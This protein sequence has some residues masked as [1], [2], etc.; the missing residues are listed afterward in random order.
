MFYSSG[1][2]NKILLFWW[3]PHYRIKIN[4]KSN[5]KSSTFS[6]HLS[7]FLSPLV[8]FIC[9][10][11]NDGGSFNFSYF[12]YGHENIKVTRILCLCSSIMIWLLEFSLRKETKMK[13]RMIPR[14]NKNIWSTSKPWSLFFNF[15][16]FTH[17]FIGAQTNNIL[18][19]TWGHS[20][21]P[22]MFKFS[23]IGP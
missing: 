19:I 15:N 9:L 17:E 6:F 20:M 22:K 18:L 14:M 23:I 12:G 8:E 13:K 16:D 2:Y 3:N 7:S 10:F 11:V 1:C 21:N 5:L 4:L